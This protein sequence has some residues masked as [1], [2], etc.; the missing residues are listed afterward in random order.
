MDRKKII[1]ERK[2]MAMMKMAKK[3]SKIVGIYSSDNVS[4]TQ[5]DSSNFSEVGEEEAPK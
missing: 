4:G 2:R 3:R 1:Q 5:D